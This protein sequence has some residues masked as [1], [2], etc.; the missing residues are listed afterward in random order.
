MVLSRIVYNERRV[1][2]VQSRAVRAAPVDRGGAV[3]CRAV[4]IRRSGGG[5]TCMHHHSHPHPLRPLWRPPAR[6]LH[7]AC[8]GG[9]DIC[10]STGERGERGNRPPDGRYAGVACPVFCPLPFS[11]SLDSAQQGR[12]QCAVSTRHRLCTVGRLLRRCSWLTA[13]RGVTPALRAGAALQA[14]QSEASAAT[15]RRRHA[16]TSNFTRAQ[17][18]PIHL[19]AS[20]GVWKAFISCGCL[21]STDLSSSSTA[22]CIPRHPHHRH[23]TTLTD[24]THVRISIDCRLLV[25]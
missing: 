1:C 8:V 12:L 5:A 24:T 14:R 13:A 10:L 19:S 15:R 11:D 9:V 21:R 25:E 16:Y 20:S 23:Y 18:N 2:S 22:A 7:S 3:K 17:L 6:P 4:N